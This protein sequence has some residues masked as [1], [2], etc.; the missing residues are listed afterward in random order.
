MSFQAYRS[1]EK[2]A[3]V[4]AIFLFHVLQSETAA[5][6]SSGYNRHPTVV[7]T[8]SIHRTPH[9]TLSTADQ[10]LGDLKDDG[11]K[12]DY[13]SWDDD[14]DALFTSSNTA[15][16]GTPLPEQS[17]DAETAK[18]SHFF[19]R[20]DLEDQSFRIEENLDNSLF[21][22]LCM[23]AGIAR[24]SKIQSLAWPVLLKGK[25]ALVADQ[26][27][28]GK[29]LAYLLPLLQRALQANNAQS[30]GRIN[31][32]PRILILAPTA[33]L[34]DQIRAVCAKLSQKVKFSTMVVTS[35]GA[36]YSTLIRDQIRMIQRQP[37]DVLI[38]T[39]GRISTI[40][41]SKNSGGLDLSHLQA[42]VLD[43]VDVLL[44]DD[45]TF[46]PQLRTIGVATPVEQ[47]QFVFVTATLPDSIVKRVEMEF[48]DVVQVKG[49]GLHRIAPTL[50][51]HLV[52]VSVPSQYNRDAQ[53]CF[54]V[55][56]KQLL[57]A[58][59]QTRCQ[60]TL[61][62]CNTVE[63]CRS[64]ENLLNRRDRKGQI[65]NVLPYHNA[66]TPEAR[67][68]NLIKFCKG[69][70][71]EQLPL[72]SRMTA[73]SAKLNQ[74]ADAILVCTDRAAR[75]VDF[76]AAPVDHVILFDFP[77]DPAEYVRRVGRTARAGRSGTSTVFAFG[78]QLP[79]A[80]SVM[81]KKL[82]SFSIAFND[83]KDED[84]DY[85]FRGG[86]KRRHKGKKAD[87]EAIKSNIELGKLWE[88]K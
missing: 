62:F 78:W 69:S 83:E 65:Y 76:A 47:T 38:S 87:M 36:H 32:A 71:G 27:G 4:L 52:D 45:E 55:K 73:R 30:H 59:R 85:D 49:P 64:V 68:A 22:N 74:P 35:S 15:A 84:E 11:E 2:R 46:G 6:A 25:H 29:T 77:K 57:N 23:G 50:T 88:G 86:A 44:M 3:I 19:S 21:Q 33:E 75:G 42:L 72:K 37:I 18:P 10:I 14:D 61:I 81:G 12:Y 8:R 67:N 41:R 70:G 58:L 39:P 51:E 66:M 7:S 20:K 80:R 1:A 56:A 48:P 60:R 40:L 79:I 54:D 5:F 16:V 9:A 53:F 63:S 43:E 17:T 28:S 13:N 82:D 24:P 26:T 31:G 34:A